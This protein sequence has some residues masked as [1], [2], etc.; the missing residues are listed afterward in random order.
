MYPGD[1]TKTFSYKIRLADDAVT[2]MRVLV[3]AVG[4]CLNL[5]ASSD[6]DNAMYD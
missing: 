5:A 3:Y 6:P 4:Q 1:K 2:N